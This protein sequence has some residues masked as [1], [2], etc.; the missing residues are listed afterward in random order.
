MLT[1][2]QKD[3][4]KNIL[5]NL[6]EDWLVDNADPVSDETGLNWKGSDEKEAKQHAIETFESDFEDLDYGYELTDEEP[7]TAK[8]EQFKA[9]TIEYAKQI[10]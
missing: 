8:Y 1:K 5:D 9:E 10:L 2:E 4:I 6:Q 7:F 3:K